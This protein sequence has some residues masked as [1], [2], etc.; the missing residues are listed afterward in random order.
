MLEQS[1]EDAHQAC[2][3]LALKRKPEGSW[4]EMTWDARRE[5]YRRKEKG[6][7]FTLDLTCITCWLTQYNGF[8]TIL[9]PFSP[10]SSNSF[11]T[12]FIVWFICVIDTKL[13]SLVS[14]SL[15]LNLSLCI[16]FHFFK[17]HLY[18]NGRRIS[19]SSLLSSTLT[20]PINYLT[21][22]LELF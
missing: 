14:Q 12:M 19:R 17:C 10:A 4:N 16:L 13:I 5:L 21:S 2:G 3:N 9:S 11:Y 7:V 15:M 22:L 18:C 8:S 20:Y 1:E 6:S